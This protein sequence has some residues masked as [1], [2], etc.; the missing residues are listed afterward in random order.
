MTLSPMPRNLSVFDVL[1]LLFEIVGFGRAMIQ[2]YGTRISRLA[3]PCMKDVVL[4][5]STA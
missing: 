5:T 1:S 4:L 2:M 3:L